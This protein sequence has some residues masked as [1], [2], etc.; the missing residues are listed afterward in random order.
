MANN[1]SMTLDDALELFES[2]CCSKS[3]FKLALEKKCYTKWTKM[4][5][6]GLTNEESPE[7]EYL[8]KTKGKEEIE[9]RKKFLGLDKEAAASVY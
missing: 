3:H 8:L 9:R 4:D 5:D 2:V 1:H 7:Y 6:F